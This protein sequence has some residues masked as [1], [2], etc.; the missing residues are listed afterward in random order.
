MNHHSRSF[1][2]FRNGQAHLDENTMPIAGLS[3]R[4]PMAFRPNLA[5]IAQ[6]PA[7]DVQRV[8]MSVQNLAADFRCGFTLLNCH[9]PGFGQ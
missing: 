4:L 8:A 5:I 6:N 9:R 7:I 1:V 2:V 3:L